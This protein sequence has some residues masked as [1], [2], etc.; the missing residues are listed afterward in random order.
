MLTL[1]QLQLVILFVI[2]NSCA[3][4]ITCTTDRD[5]FGLNTSLARC[6]SSTQI[7]NCTD[8]LVDTNEGFCLLNPCF[9][10]VNNTCLPFDRK[11]KNVTL[12]LAIFLT[13]LGA[14]NFYIS[15]WVMGAIQL[16]ITVLTWIPVIFFTTFDLILFTISEKNPRKCRCLRRDNVFLSAFVCTIIFLIIVI[17]LGV[18]IVIWWF[19]DVIAVS[20]GGRTDGR[21]CALI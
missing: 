14:A 3:S 5:C 21:G 11:S 17:L 4:H 10:L 6:E 15:Q 1:I 12:L 20:T 16:T 19:I 7:C 18:V 2:F 13:S 8:C 9:T